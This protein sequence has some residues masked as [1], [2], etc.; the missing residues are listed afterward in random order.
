MEENLNGITVAI[1]APSGYAMEPA[2]VERAIA[3][4][5]MRGCRVRNFYDGS[6][7]HQRFGAADAVRAR[8]LHAA[9]ADPDVDLVLALR[10][11][12]GMSRI[13][14]MLDLNSLGTSGK[15]FVGHS[16]FTALQMALLAHTG[17]TSFAGPMICDD[18]SR[19]EPSDY[20]LQQFWQC[21][22]S[23][24][25]TI[26]FSAEDNPAIDVAGVL[27]GGN[28][29]MLAHLAGTPYLPRIDDGILFIEDVNEHPYR[30]ERMLL[31]LHHAGRL[32]QKAIVLGDFSAYRLNEYDNG[33]DFDA[34]LAYLRG[35]LGMPILRG[36]PF[37]HIREKTT[38]AVGAEARL[39]CDGRT[40]LL[41]MTGYP[42]LL[43]RL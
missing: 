42:T 29:T 25:H 26:A 28:L 23:R 30:V 31:Q 41:T 27:W 17:A 1:V 39:Q 43:R 16:D 35:Q 15:L 20:T 21:V 19:E 2:A 38:L 24:E 36:L 9:A 37:G 18:F 3:R 32:R 11:G 8:Q 10:G 34:M 13:L 5:E 14:P 6:A 4:L 7:K 22:R 12:Y 40:S 33:Y